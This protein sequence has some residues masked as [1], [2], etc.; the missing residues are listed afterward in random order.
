M[1]LDILV[2]TFHFESIHSAGRITYDL[3]KL[4]WINKQWISRIEPE[5]LTLLCRPIL[6][7]TY[8]NAKYIDDNTLTKLLQIIKTEL[9]TLN[10]VIQALEFYFIEPSITQTDFTACI[11]ET[12][13]II[14][15]KIIQNNNKYL[16]QPTEYNTQIKLAAKIENIPL[17]ELFWF[18]RLAFIG[19]TNGPS[20]HELLEML[21]Y[22]KAEKR[23]AK[24][25][26]LLS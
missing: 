13:Y 20:I 17:K 24:A 25:L 10:D 7:K 14:I 8:E 9:V 19:K 21:E 12:S 4:K 26:N 22:D 5:K 3:E 18:L 1:P 15:K 2:K 6:E 11:P 23:I 16:V